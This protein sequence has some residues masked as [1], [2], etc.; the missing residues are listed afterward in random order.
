V[1]ITYAQALEVLSSTEPTVAGLSD[2]VRSVSG[3]VEGATSQT[4]YLLNSGPMPNG[5]STVRIVA[6][7]QDEG[8]AVSF[9]MSE[10]GKFLNDPSGVQTSN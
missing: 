2:L 5:E 3:A 4:T 7:L 8:A 9:G 1:S 10:A 6:A